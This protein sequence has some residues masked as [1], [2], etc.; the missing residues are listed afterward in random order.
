MGGG[1][2][3]GWGGVGVSC[4]EQGHLKHVIGRT[5]VLI[6]VREIY[7]NMY[8]RTL[9]SIHEKLAPNSEVRQAKVLKMLSTL[10]MSAESS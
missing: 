5:E 1:V 7:M 10:K 6:V 4:Q 8:K 3:E 2:N 9:H